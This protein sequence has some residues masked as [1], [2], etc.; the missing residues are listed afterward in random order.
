MQSVDGAAGHIDRAVSLSALPLWSPAPA[1]ALLILSGGT[2]RLRLVAVALIIPA[3]VLGIIVG[4]CQSAAN[5]SSGQMNPASDEP[6][7]LPRI[8]RPLSG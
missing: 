7:G 3:I 1:P 5:G 2:T 4:A 6:Q 8:E